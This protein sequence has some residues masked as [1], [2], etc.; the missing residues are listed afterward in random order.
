MR[1]YNTLFAAALLLLSSCGGKGDRTGWSDTIPVTIYVVGDEGSSDERNYVGDIGSEREVTLSFPLGGT[2]TNVAVRNGQHVKQGQLLAEVDATRARSLHSTA[3]ATLRQAEDAYRRLEA[4]HREGG[5]SEVKWVEMETNLEK[6]RQTELTARKSLDDCIIRAPFAGVVATGDHHVGQEMKP[7][8][9]FGRVLD[10]GRLRVNFSV[11]EQ[12]ILYIKVG[13]TATATVPSLDNRQFS[14]RISDKS[15]IANPFGH[16]YRVN[17]VI[18]GGAESGSLLPDMV[19]KVHVLLGDAAGIAVPA[20]CVQTMPEG[21][22]LWVVKN[23]KAEHRKVTVGD[24][25]RNSVIIDEGLS[26]GDTV[27]IAGY[28]KL[29]TGAKVKVQ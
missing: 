21:T 7:T 15:L 9:P 8:E 11:P 29:Y 13:D 26:A 18:T 23:G 12:D 20:D 24:F 4:V 6:A 25:S 14:L 28:Q 2:L 5:L 17:A 1:Q 19:A 27:V 10:M 3:V 16:T 22:I